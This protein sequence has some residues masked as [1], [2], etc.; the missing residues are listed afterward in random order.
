MPPAACGVHPSPRRLIL[1]FA[2][3][4]VLAL[5]DPALAPATEPTG[6]LRI[7]LP[8]LP[9][10]LDPT[11]AGD[12]PGPTSPP[13]IV[14][15]QLFEGLVEFGERGDLA[16][17]LASQWSVSRDGLTWT[18]RLR[19][20]VRFHNG[21]LLTPD[22]V[23]ASL[24]RQMGP[25]APV[26]T[27]EPTWAR[28]LRGPATLVRDVRRGEPE[29]VQILLTQPFS[30]LL[31]VLAHPAFAIVVSQNGGEMP[32]SGTG[33]YRVAA[34]GPGRLTLEAAQPHGESPRTARLVLEEIAED[35]TGLAE[36]GPRGGLHVHFPQAPPA[37]GGLGLQTLTGPT[38]QTGLLAMRTHE[39]LFGRKGARQAVAGSLDPGLVVPALGP[40][41]RPLT[42]YLPPGAWAARETLPAGFDPARARRLLA[43]AR[44]AGATATILVRDAAEGPD[45][46]RLAE[47]IRL[48]LAVAGMKVVIRAETGEAYRQALR[49]G[50]ADLALLETRLEVNDPHFGLRPLLSSDAAIPGNAT[51]VAFYRHPAVDGLLLRGSQFSFRPERLR[52][53]H[54]IQAHLADELPYIPL[55][56]RL[57][58]AVARPGVRELRLD[59]TGRHRLDR[60][61]L[62]APA[63][64]P[65]PGSIPLPPL[66]PPALPVPSRAAPAPLAAP[67]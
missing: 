58:W 63:E 59:P 48:S 1:Q 51:N 5:A 35:A 21:A 44:G 67:R 19:P 7:G 56:V 61:W 2:A 6:E 43:E 13:T 36:L 40:M 10:S 53:Y 25:Q 20:D 9:A 50:E 32:F 34:R 8:R 26:A 60:V 27:D 52:L 66:A 15:R 41:A 22:V 55:Y 49:Q 12:G 65:V 17:G 31:A 14:F 47:A 37:W 33:P 4:L 28:V 11:T 3:L 30:P 64:P 38:W 62:P 18:F 24:L 29:T 46:P 54:R 45:G 57:Q 16:P 42:A 39:G 23:I